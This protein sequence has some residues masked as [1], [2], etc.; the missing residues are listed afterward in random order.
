VAATLSRP[1]GVVTTNGVATASGYSPRTM[2]R[3]EAPLGLGR[4]PRITEVSW[5]RMTVAGLG[6]GKD[7]KLYPGGGRAWD[8]AETGTQH[9]PGIQPADVQELLDQGVTVVVLSRGMELRLQVMPETIAFLREQGV[10]V[11]L[12]ETT[13]AVEVYNQLTATRRVGGLFHSTC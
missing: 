13:A 7:F 2:D 6:T 10:Q 1:R 9:N 3:L 12:D 11:H 4:S 5:G 8:W